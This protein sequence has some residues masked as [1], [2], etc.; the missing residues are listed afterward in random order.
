MSHIQQGM[1]LR[2]SWRADLFNDAVQLGTVQNSRC[3]SS[4]VMS[5]PFLLLIFILGSNTNN[6]VETQFRL[7]KEEV[8]QRTRAFNSVHL[9]QYI[10]VE[11]DQ[12]TARK[13]LDVANCR[14]PLIERAA[15]EV[16]T[17]FTVGH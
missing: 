8:L 3:T 14:K 9:L 2:G 17:Q 6:Y 12:H 15:N 7:L 11:Y 13:L 4:L 1:T 5:F 16:I 10:C